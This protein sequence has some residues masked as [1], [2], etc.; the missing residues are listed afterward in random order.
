MYI[1][2]T[3]KVKEVF[4][5]GRRICV[6][7][8]MDISSVGKYHNGY[9]SVLKKNYGKHYSDFID[10]IETDE[11]TYSGNLDHFKDKRIP[12]KVWFFGFDSAHYWNKLH[13]ES[14]TFESVKARTIL[15]A[16]E[17]IKKRI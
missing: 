13:P 5:V 3:C 8:E 12:E 16:K 15:L 4:K 6:V 7:V 14:K 2:D 1:E 11:L 17:M 10:R 9:V